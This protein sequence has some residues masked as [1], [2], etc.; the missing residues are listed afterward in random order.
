MLTDFA[1]LSPR[2]EY[3]RHLRMRAEQSHTNECSTRFS[4]NC[5]RVLVFLLLLTWVY[6]VTKQDWES[7]RVAMYFI[8]PIVLLAI[9]VL[10]VCTQVQARR[11][12]A[13]ELEIY[14]VRRETPSTATEVVVTPV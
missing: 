3:I 10:E 7:G 6:Y 5:L 8:T 2:D 14:K 12:D 13:L 9:P 11:T 1:K 4:S